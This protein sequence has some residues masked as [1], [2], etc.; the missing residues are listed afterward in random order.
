MILGEII[1]FSD[2]AGVGWD[3]FSIVI[4]SHIRA[5]S[6]GLSYNV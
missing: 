5:C 4:V 3:G 6:T 1:P 2:R